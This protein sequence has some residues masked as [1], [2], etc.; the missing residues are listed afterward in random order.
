MS[1]L[2][3]TQISVNKTVTKVR[4]GQTVTT[5]TPIPLE[6]VVY[7]SPEWRVYSTVNLIFEVL[8]AKNIEFDIANIVVEYTG[9]P[10]KTESEIRTQLGFQV[11]WMLGQMIRVSHQSIMY[12]FLHMYSYHVIQR[13]VYFDVM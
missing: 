1:L 2:K 9:L 6:W 11:E 10:L 4:Y 13:W 12:F 3:P 5:V 7:R 8:E